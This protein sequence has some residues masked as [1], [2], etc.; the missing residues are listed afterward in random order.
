M[1]IDFLLII[2]KFRFNFIMTLHIPWP[3]LVLPSM[4]AMRMRL[5]AGKFEFSIFMLIFTLKVGIPWN[6]CLMRLTLPDLA[7]GGRR[8]GEGRGGTHRLT[9]SPT[10]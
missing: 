4:M 2:I 3:Y 6:T 1:Y 5:A 10:P 9:D 7:A 8:G